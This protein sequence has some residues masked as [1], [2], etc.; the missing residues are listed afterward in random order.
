[1][2][3]NIESNDSKGE[4][5]EVDEPG[6]TSSESMFLRRKRQFSLQSSVSNRNVLGK[7][8]REVV[9]LLVDGKSSKE[10]A[11]LMNITVTTVETYRARI[12]MKLDLHS[13]VQL[14]RYAVQNK[15]V[16]F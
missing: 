4:K 15:L 11:P 5:L 7:R 8:E 13:V 6:P 1:M 14:V 12:M 3:R 10:I 2:A 9:R 16:Q